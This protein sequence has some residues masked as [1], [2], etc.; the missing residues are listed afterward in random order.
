MSKKLKQSARLCILKSFQSQRATGV[1][2]NF[3][4][5]SISIIVKPDTVFVHCQRNVSFQLTSHPFCHNLNLNSLRS[6]LLET[7]KLSLHAKLVLENFFFRVRL[8]CNRK[9][10]SSEETISLKI[11]NIRTIFSIAG[12]SNL[13]EATRRCQLRKKKKT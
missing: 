6:P 10:L 12:F 4:K 5:T 8:D 1:K 13:I 2:A 7:E 11:V 3:N 9:Q